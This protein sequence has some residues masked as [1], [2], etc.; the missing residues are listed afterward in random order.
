MTTAF[1]YYI[2][3]QYRSR[4]EVNITANPGT[5]YSKNREKSN[6]VSTLDKQM[7]LAGCSAISVEA[8]LQRK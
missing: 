4:A 1:P 8:H 6:L 2:V 7:I 5:S 3:R